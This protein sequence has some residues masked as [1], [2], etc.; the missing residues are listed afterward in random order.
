MD[1]L[2]KK[3]INRETIAYVLGGA[4]T[5]FINF[6]TYEAF[7]RLGLTNL[8]S[9]A[10]AWVVAVAL[11][12]LV[13]KWNVFHSKSK[14]SKDEALKVIKFFGARAL[15]LGIEQLG[16]YV[17]VELMGIYRWIIKGSLSIIV[18]VLNYVFSKFYIF[19]S[20]KNRTKDLEDQPPHKNL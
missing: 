19:R 20:Q 8:A 13:N 11:A 14:N 6:I 10:V 5:T 15:T 18:I 7:Y 16:L 4:L 17:F 1:K 2:I 12:Y 3:I 9:N